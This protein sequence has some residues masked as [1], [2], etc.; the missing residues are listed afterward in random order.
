M[1][2]VRTSPMYNKDNRSWSNQRGYGFI[3]LGH[4]VNNRNM[5]KVSPWNKLMALPAPYEINVSPSL[6][7]KPITRQEAGYTKT[8]CFGSPTFRE[9]P[10][11]VIMRAN[12]FDLAKF[13]CLG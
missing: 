13:N 5:W 11:K 8:T 1:Q 9:L 3:H 10:P 2:Q 4:N 7:W 12:D 6:A